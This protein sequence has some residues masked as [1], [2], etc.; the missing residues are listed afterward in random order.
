[1]GNHSYSWSGA[2]TGNLISCQRSFSL[3]GTYTANLSVTS[4]GK[5]KIASC[6]VKVEEE[7]SSFM[8]GTL[9]VNPR[10]VYVNNPITITVTGYNSYGLSAIGSH[11]KGNWDIK[12]VSGTNS[13][14][15]W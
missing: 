9:S 2:C 1:M 8:S 4:G 11:Y 13:T 12:D 10:T 5:T 6:T 3:P 15:T 7:T 14:K